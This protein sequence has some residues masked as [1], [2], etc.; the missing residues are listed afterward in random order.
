MAAYQPIKRFISSLRLSV[1]RFR[2]PFSMP[3]DVGQDLGVEVTNRLDFQSFLKQLSSSQCH[4]QKIWRYMSREEVESM[5]S[6]AFRTDRFRDKTR[7]AYYF[8]QGWVEFELKFDEHNQL[9]RLFLQS[10]HLPEGGALEIP[11]LRSPI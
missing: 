3:E 9:R 6:H 7:F 8:K 2:Y 1:D 10:C 5:F 11:L 4:P